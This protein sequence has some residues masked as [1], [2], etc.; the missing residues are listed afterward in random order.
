MTTTASQIE[1][2]NQVYNKYKGVNR[3]NKLEIQ[4]SLNSIESLIKRELQY[5]KDLRKVDYLLFQLS[6]R[7]FYKTLIKK[8]DAE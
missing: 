6:Q 5:S 2:A 3:F 4:N 7:V 1:K 8:F